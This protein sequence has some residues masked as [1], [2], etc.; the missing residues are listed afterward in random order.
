MNSFILVP[1]DFTEAA[2]TALKHGAFA[3]EKSGSKLYLLHL[4]KSNS[5]LDDAKKRVKDQIAEVETTA[6]VEGVVRVGDFKDITQ[7]AKEMSVEL[8]FLGTHGAK[9]MQKVM[10]S[11]ALK[12]VTNSDI[13]FIIIQKGAPIPTGYQ[14]ILAPTSFHFESKQKIKAIASIANY[15]KSVVY[16]VYKEESDVALKAKNLSNLKFMKKQLDNEGIR[17]GVKTS[18]GKNFNNDTLAIAKETEADLIAIMNMQKSS[19][20]GS[21]L[22]GDKYEQELLMNDLLIP[23]LII[24][25]KQTNLTPG[26][27]MGRQ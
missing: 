7:I 14:K 11:N 22:L 21:G 23:V 20:F 19:I 4:C 2:N 26:V 9:G 10:G 17:Y 6:E 1:T 16:F 27:L 12:L 3:A 18:R 25:P 15:F 5:E 8:I 24:S 13:P